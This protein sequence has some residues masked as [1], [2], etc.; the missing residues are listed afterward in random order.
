MLSSSLRKLRVN[1]CIEDLCAYNQISHTEAEKI[2]IEYLDICENQ[3]MQ[4][5]LKEFDR[6]KHTLDKYLFKM[7]STGSDTY[8]Y[9]IH[10]MKFVFVCF[11]GNAEVERGFSINSECLITNLAEDSLTAQRSVISAVAASGGVENVNITKSML[12]AFKGASMKRT[13][14]LKEKKQREDNE[15]SRIKTVAVQIS[16]LQKQKTDI[17]NAQT[18]DLANLDDKIKLLKKQLK[19]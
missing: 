4:R 14:A 6:E 17:L 19:K 11:H 8:K 15:E 3:E 1:I 16:N 18:E 9:F 5:K 7:L 13:T 2:K 12:M 10:F